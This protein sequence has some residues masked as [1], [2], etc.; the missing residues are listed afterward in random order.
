MQ[1]F[2]G[3]PPGGLIDAADDDLFRIVRDHDRAK[4]HAEPVNDVVHQSA[5]ERV[6]A[7]GKVEDHLHRKRFLVQRFA[8][9]GVGVFV[10]PFARVAQHVFLGR[11]DLET[12][13]GAAK[14]GVMRRGIDDDMPEFAHEAVRTVD[15][16]VIFQNAAARMDASGQKIHKT[17]GSLIVLLQK[18]CIAAHGGGVFHIDGNVDGKLTGNVAADGQVA[19]PGVLHRIADHAV[20]H[21]ENAVACN[22]RAAD[23]HARVAGQKRPCGFSRGPGE[24]VVVALGQSVDPDRVEAAAVLGQEA[25]RRPRTDP[26]G[27]K[28]RSG[29]SG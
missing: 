24:C 6:A 7:V 14:A 21:V 9:G 22:D 12:A 17:R 18:L 13:L 11:H 23:A 19:P 29:K 4:Q 26:D 28:T 16:F 2:E 5:G 20:I 25:K 27:S 15:K 3:I 1:R 8:D 10:P